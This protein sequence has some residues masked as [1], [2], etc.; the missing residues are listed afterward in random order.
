MNLQDKHNKLR[1]DIAKLKANHQRYKHKEKE[2]K[3][4]TCKL[5]DQT[6]KRYYHSN[7]ITK[8]KRK[9]LEFD[10]IMVYL[11][12]ILTAYLIYKMGVMF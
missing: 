4:L 7:A 3:M 10:S 6:T 5:L 12:L 9:R 11:V 8:P 1:A 2:L